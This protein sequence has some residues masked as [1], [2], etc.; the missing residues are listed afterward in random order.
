MLFSKPIGI[1][2]ELGI[3]KKKLPQLFLGPQRFGKI[4]PRVREQTSTYEDTVN[5]APYGGIKIDFGLGTLRRPIPKFWKKDFW[6]S[7]YRKKMPYN[8]WNSGNHWFILTIPI[9]PYIFV[10]M[11][12]GRW[13]KKEITPGFYIGGRTAYVNNW[14]HWLIDTSKISESGKWPNNKI[15]WVRD[16]NGNPILAWGSMKEEGN[17][18]IEPT[19]SIRS[20]FSH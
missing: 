7:D 14:T 13:G 17:V 20:D 8:P 9:I 12:F 19:A 4:R 11:M 15:P 1:T 16:K 18:Y 2:I 5:I 3:N 10:M 6:S